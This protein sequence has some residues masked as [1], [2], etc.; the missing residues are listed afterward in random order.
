MR[1]NTIVLFLFASAL[2][3]SA[4]NVDKDKASLMSEIVQNNTTLAAFRQKANAAKQMNGVDNALPDP[5]FN[6]S[7]TWGNQPGTITSQSYSIEQELDW[8]TLSGQR[9]KTTKSTNK[10]VDLNYLVQ[11]QTILAEA[12]RLIVELT[13]Y[14]ALCDELAMREERAA[15]LK[16]LYQ[17]K[18]EA[19]D[20]D[21]L[22][23]NKVKLSHT[24]TIAELRKAKADR[25]AVKEDLQRLNGNQAIIYNHSRYAKTVIPPL[26]ELIKKAETIAP[27]IA[28][29]TQS[30]EVEQQKLKLNKSAAIPNLTVGYAGS[31]ARKVRTNA[32]TIGI[33]IPLW[34]NSRKKVSQ[35]RAEIAVAEME[36]NDVETQIKATLQRQFANATSLEQ[37][38][39]QF[40]KE[41]NENEDIIILDKALDAGKLSLI[42]Y[43]NE[44]TFYYSAHT[45]ALE[46]ERDAQLAISDLWTIFR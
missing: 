13:Y 34:G 33:D 22:E 31:S 45:Q 32:V 14:N 15:N 1:K 18:Y 8:G 9:R 20:A 26:A 3:I 25:D 29:V 37:I 4:Q 42:E 10:A 17:K 27:Q 28:L 7:N 24:A 11:R 2:S 39:N 43:L 35:Q 5:S 21:K 36:K 44:I 12:D 19:G 16:L 40:H 30:I 6:F 23:L 38:S 46:A 41:L